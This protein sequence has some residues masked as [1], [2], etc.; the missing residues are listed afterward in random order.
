VSGERYRR[1]SAQR[2][3]DNKLRVWGK[4]ADHDGNV[5]SVGEDIEASVRSAVRVAVAGEVDCDKRSVECEGNGVPRMGVLSSAV[6]EHD[7][8]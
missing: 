5:F 8:W 2:H 7:L 6:Q 1:H 3:T 4:F